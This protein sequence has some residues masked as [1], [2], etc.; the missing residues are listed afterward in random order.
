MRSQ[1]EYIHSGTV[2]FHFHALWQLVWH[3][4]VEVRCKNLKPVHISGN[5]MW[6]CDTK[7]ENLSCGGLDM[8]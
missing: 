8:F 2:D 3:S 5:P 1:G 6:G 7:V 4:A